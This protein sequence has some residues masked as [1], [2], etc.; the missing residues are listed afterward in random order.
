[1]F[2]IVAEKVGK[3]GTKKQMIRL[4]TEIIDMMDDLIED[5]RLYATKPD[6]IVYSMRVYSS[7]IFDSLTKIV[8]SDIDPDE[9]DPDLKKLQEIVSDPELLKYIFSKNKIG[10]L[11]GLD[12]DYFGNETKPIMIHIPNGMA[13][14]IDYIIKNVQ[15]AR[16]LNDFIKQSISFNLSKHYYHVIMME[17]LNN[18]AENGLSRS[19]DMQSIMHILSKI[20][21]KLITDDLVNL[22][23][24]DKIKKFDHIQ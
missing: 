22:F 10:I 6:F 4:P 15:I 1:M 8:E 21:N 12:D 16:S 17:M 5:S 23:L 19:K 24:K 20:N 18:Y 11:I 14:E 7:T 9:T 3:S 13:D 2:I